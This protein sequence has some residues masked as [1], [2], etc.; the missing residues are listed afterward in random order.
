MEKVVAIPVR[1]NP[2]QYTKRVLIVDDSEVIRQ[3]LRSL[4]SDT[5]N[6]ELAGEAEDTQSAIDLWQST[7]PDIVILDLRMPGGGGINVLRE[8]KKQS[9]ETMVVI[10][11]NYPYIAYRKRCIELGADYFF[12]KS[13]EFGKVKDIVL[14]GEKPR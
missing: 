11:T 1:E 2:R 13:L 8:I 4:I 9:P 6:V 3:R 12:D 5:E 10:L 7:N 14:R